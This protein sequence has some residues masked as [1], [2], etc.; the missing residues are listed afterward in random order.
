M[1]S[2][3]LIDQKFPE[4]IQKDILGATDNMLDQLGIY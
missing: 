4:S 3:A 1:Y 2:A